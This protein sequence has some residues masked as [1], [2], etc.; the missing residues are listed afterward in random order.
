[1]IKIGLVDDDPSN[2]SAIG[3]LLRS[4]GYECVAYESAECALA[5]P[6]FLRMGCVLIDIELLG[7]N[8]FDLRDRL[9]GLGSGV[10]HIFVTAHSEADFPHW[11]TRMHDSLWLTKPVD[12]QV[13]ISTI[14]KMTLPS[15]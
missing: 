1:M 10:P 6:A 15:G 11:K 8:G 13:L 9:L 4:Y 2:R 5:D 14:E 7:M 12:E 3:R